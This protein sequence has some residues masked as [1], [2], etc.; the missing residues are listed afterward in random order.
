MGQTLSPAGY[1]HS[2]A[3]RRLVL[4]EKTFVLKPKSIRAAVQKRRN[5]PSVL[6]ALRVDVSD[7]LV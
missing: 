6:A 7:I 5:D 1:F 2:L 3:E 4:N